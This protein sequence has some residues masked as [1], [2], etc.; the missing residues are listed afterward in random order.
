MILDVVRDIVIV[1]LIQHFTVH[2]DQRF[3]DQRTVRE[4]V[5]DVKEYLDFSLFFAGEVSFLAK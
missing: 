5:E 2:V 4:L 3:L 1:Q